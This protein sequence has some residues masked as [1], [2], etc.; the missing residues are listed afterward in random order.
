M[1]HVALIDRQGFE[2]YGNAEG[3]GVRRGGSEAFR[4]ARGGFFARCAAG[5]SAL[6][7]RAKDQDAVG[8]EIGAAQFDAMKQALRDLGRDRLTSPP[9]IRS[10]P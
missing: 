5:G 3:F 9:P 10:A 6:F 2:Q 1:Y 7:G 4:H 8:S